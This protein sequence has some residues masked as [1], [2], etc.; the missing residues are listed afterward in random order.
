MVKVCAILRDFLWYN[1]IK[2][3]GKFDG[4]SEKLTEFDRI[5][6][7]IIVLTAGQDFAF[8]RKILLSAGI[9]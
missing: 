6:Y 4:V 9:D 3:M 1:G 7:G 8:R 2:G 5:I